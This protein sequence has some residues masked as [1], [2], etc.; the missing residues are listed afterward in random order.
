M[1]LIGELR[2]RNVLRVAA[3]YVALGW[4]LVEMAETIFPLFGFDDGPARMVVILLAV[5]FVPTMIFSWVFEF[6]PEGLK[7][8]SEVDR[9]RSITTQTGKRIDRIFLVV[10]ALAAVTIHQL[11][12]LPLLLDPE[13]LGEAVGR[14]GVWGPLIFVAAFAAMEPFFVPGI[15]FMLG[16]AWLLNRDF[17]PGLLQEYADL[18]WP[19]T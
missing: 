10:L 19:F 5:G 7:R 12:L 11:G 4:L 17:P 14:L 6:T 18:P 13:A 16:M 15:A 8:E 2:R 1:S 9:S 3:A